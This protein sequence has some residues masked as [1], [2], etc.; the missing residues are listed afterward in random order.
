MTAFDI[1]ETLKKVF[2]TIWNELLTS[3]S[4]WKEHF[5]SFFLIFIT[6]LH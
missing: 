2:E 3:A 5:T 4:R 6:E 1:K